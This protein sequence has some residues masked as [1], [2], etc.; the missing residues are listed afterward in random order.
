MTDPF[1]ICLASKG[2][3]YDGTLKLLERCIIPVRRAKG[4]RSY[5]A[6]I[7]GLDDVKVILARADEIPRLLDTGQAHVGITGLDLVTESAGEGLTNLD[8]V[9]PD[10]GFGRADLVVGVPQ[11][12]LD[13]SSIDDLVEVANDVRHHHGRPVRVATKFPSLTRS[14]FR[15]HGLTDYRIVE[16]LGATEGAPRAG[17][18][19]L[20]VD[21]TSTGT[22]L[23]SNGLK[24]IAGGTVLRSQACLVGG[25]RPEL[26][27][28][29]Q[30]A[31]L[32]RL[33]MLLGA[34]LAAERQRLVRA[35]FAELDADRRAEV[36]A[37]LLQAFWTDQPG[38]VE[39]SGTAVTRNVPTLLGLLR[40]AGSLLAT[41][42]GSG[43]ILGDETDHVDRFV[44]QLRR[45]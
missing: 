21:L 39:L 31:Q 10:L 38:A 32:R 14:F 37:L 33:V 3:L 11:A 15:S 8:V 42:E 7:D 22:T 43:L 34:A 12:W 6:T 18:A 44:G 2:S 36:E 13:V 9:V 40:A 26:W 24:Q 28:E 16:S 29:E 27:P 20:V 23:A 41:V 45:S 17:N 30:V 5:E 1:V 4:N 19:D 25:S 35:R